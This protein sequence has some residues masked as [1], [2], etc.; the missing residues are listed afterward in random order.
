MFRAIRKTPR[1]R[2]CAANRPEKRVIIFCGYAIESSFSDGWFR[3]GGQNRKEFRKI[4]GRKFL[5]TGEDVYFLF[6]RRVTGA[7]R[8]A[9]FGANGSLREWLSDLSE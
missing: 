1:I 8:R 7:N 5:R 9:K 6:Q 4:L 3:I 2:V